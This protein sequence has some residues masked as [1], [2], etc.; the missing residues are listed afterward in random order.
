M[1]SDTQSRLKNIDLEDA[2]AKIAGLNVTSLYLAYR[3]RSRKREEYQEYTRQF[4]AQTWLV[5]SPT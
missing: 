3:D 5:C 2:D 4:Q 1:Y